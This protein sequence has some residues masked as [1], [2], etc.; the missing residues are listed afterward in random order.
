MRSWHCNFWLMTAVFLMLVLLPRSVWGADR[1]YGLFVSDDPTANQIQRATTR[2]GVAPCAITIFWDWDQHRFQVDTLSTIWNEGAIP[3]VTLEPWYAAKREGINLKAL[4]AG[5]E[6]AVLVAFGKTIAA[7]GHPVI[8]RFAHEMNG[9]WYPWSGAA[10]GKSGADFVAAWRHVR[11]VVSKAAS[12]IPIIWALTFN[13]EDVPLEAWN[14]PDRYDPG[15]EMVDVVAIDGYNGGER[16]PPHQWRSFAAV[17]E[18]QIRS[19]RSLF[20]GK[21]ILILETASAAGKDRAAWITAFFERMKESFADIPLFV[22]FDVAK[23]A[24]WRI[25]ADPASQAAFRKGVVAV[26]AG[27]R[28]TLLQRL[29]PSGRP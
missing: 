19:L 7:F 22:W 10:H 2:Y 9:N 16:L 17:A 28:E 15:R 13:A 11:G 21:P 4:A 29:L 8:V 12:P 24:D 27:T 20:P 3:V 26:F 5:H 1:C 25:A 18:K 23:E 6:D 14:A